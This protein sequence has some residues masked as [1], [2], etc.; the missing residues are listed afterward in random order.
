[1][2]YFLKWKIASIIAEG[3]E[4]AEPAPVL[5]ISGEEVSTS[6]V[7]FFSKFLLLVGFLI[8]LVDC[9]IAPWLFLFQTMLL[10]MV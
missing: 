10:K 5:Y 7:L 3:S 1:M 4:L 8:K 6:H 2:S 9:V